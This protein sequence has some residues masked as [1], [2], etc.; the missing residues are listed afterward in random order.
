MS[1]ETQVVQSNNNSNN[2]KEQKDFSENKYATL[3]ETSGEEHE[4]WYYFIRYNG[5]EENL[6]KL[7]TILEQIDWYILDDLS[8][9]DLET[10]YLVC[11][12]TAKEMTKLDLNHTSRHRKF[13]GVLN[14]VVIKF[15]KRD[16]N[17]KKMERIFDKL[18]YGQ[19]EDYIGEED[20]DPE[21]LVSSSEE[22]SS[23]ESSSLSS[24][25]EKEEKDLEEKK[26][27]KGIPKALLESNMPR[28]AKA[29][30]HRR[31]KM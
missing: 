21:D 9:F 19:I 30:Q 1:R 6:K 23:E 15:K 28:F 5:N 13:D 8:T 16:D 7:Q 29:K 12:R 2:F 31:R 4:S 24:E 18:G 25:D 14:E 22:S 17:E 27:K 10:E 3:M 20:I 26:E 11:E